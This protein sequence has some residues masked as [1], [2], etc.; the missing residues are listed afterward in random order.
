MI[1]TSQTHPLEIAEVAAGPGMGKIGITFCPGKKQAHA[2]SGAW[3]RDLVLDFTAIDRWNAAALVTLLEAHELESLGVPR[4]G[5]AV[6]DDHMIWYYLPIRDGGLPDPE[7]E[8][9]WEQSGRE[10]RAMVRDGFNVLVHCKGGLGRAGTIGARLLVELGMAPQEAVKAVRAARPGAIETA[11]QHA[12]VMGL[13]SVAEELPDTSLKAVA[14]RAQGAMLGLA[15]GDALGTTLEFTAR[16]SAPRL[17]DIVG[18][19]PFDLRPGQWTDDTAMALAL[20]DSLL[21]AP[22]LDEGDLMDRFVSWHETG[23]Y[24]CTGT[25]FDIGITTRRALQHYKRTGNPLA[26]SSDPKTAGNGSLMRLAPV[27]IRYW[28]DRRA[29]RDVAAR[30]SRTTHGARQA[31]DACVGYA[32]I[33]A[34][35]IAGHS[36]AHVLRTRRSTHDEAIARILAGS[37][38]GAHRDAIGSTGYVVHSLEAALW[39]VGRTGRFFD[40]LLLAT[41]LGEDADT[42]GAITGQLAGALY[43]AS[44]ISANSLD[45]LAWGERIRQT[46]QALFEQSLR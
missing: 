15:I 43:G 11:A 20:M 19:G 22:A 3:D 23:H 18:R 5:N 7:F 16:D 4:L 14:D 12:Y 44:G 40:A 13:A 6:H 42:T 21:V 24:S 41:N 2:A 36:R 39:S 37:W 10:L 45:Q 29:L 17:T 35:A 8:E 1:R 38:R 25:C 32:E 26:G 33:L 30:Q 46:A 9:I 28:N 34:D 27:A 31:V